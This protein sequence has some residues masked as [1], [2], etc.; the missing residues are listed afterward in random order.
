[1]SF[2]AEMKYGAFKY[3]SCTLP[4]QNGSAWTSRPQQVALTY[5]SGNIV[6]QREFS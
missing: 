6:K 4:E 1:M 5:N 2:S 3:D